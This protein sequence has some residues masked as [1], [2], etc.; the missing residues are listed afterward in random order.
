MSVNHATIKAELLN[1]YT[2]AD[3][4]EGID[5]NAFADGMATIIQNAIRSGDVQFPIAVQVSGTTH[6]GGTTEIGSIL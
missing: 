5:K 6:I 4:G 3:T 2:Q 1:L